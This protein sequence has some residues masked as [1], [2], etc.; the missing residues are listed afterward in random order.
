[1][2]ADPNPEETWVNA[3]RSFLWDRGT[4]HFSEVG[5][6]VRRPEGVCRT[7]KQVLLD[8]ENKYFILYFRGEPYTYHDMVELKR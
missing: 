5:M 8:Y 2:S 4:V 1:M 6:K 7:L 3:I